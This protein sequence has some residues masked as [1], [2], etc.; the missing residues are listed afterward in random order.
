MS[1][2][3]SSTILL[4]GSDPAL[5]MVFSRVLSQQKY[6]VKSA[7]DC[8][9]ALEM[10]KT[11]EPSLVILDTMLPRVQQRMLLTRLRSLRNCRVI[12]FTNNLTNEKATGDDGLVNMPG[13]EI[14]VRRPKSIKQILTVTKTALAVKGEK[15]AVVA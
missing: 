13:N 2:D 9:C 11:T 7:G 3:A 14:Q 1:Y 5:N 15:Q 10:L 4:V 12:H 8:L 6:R